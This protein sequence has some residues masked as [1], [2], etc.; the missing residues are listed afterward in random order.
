MF[1]IPIFTWNMLVTSI[2]V[3]IAFPMLTAAA[4]MLFA[5]RHFGAHIFDIANGLTAPVTNMW[6]AQ[7]P[8]DSA[9]MAIVAKTS[10][11]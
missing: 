7:T 2:L 10:P 8:T 5:D 4:A 3:L 1:R 9:A 6:C 11:A